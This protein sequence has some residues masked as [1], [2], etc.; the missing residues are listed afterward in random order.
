[1]GHEFWFKPK[2][3]GYGATPTTWEGWAVVA[4]YSLV[5]LACVVAMLVRKESFS[6]FA[7]SMAVIAVATVALIA[8]SLQ[9][10]DGA[11]GWN[12]GANKIAGK[13]E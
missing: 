6:T 5:I 12:A 7:A 10:T 1:M 8:V 11:W 4:V 13:S 3:F 9:K 2:T